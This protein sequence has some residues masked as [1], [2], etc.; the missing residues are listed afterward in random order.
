MADP[1]LFNF[2]GSPK[3][4]REDEGGTSPSIRPW[5]GTLASKADALAVYSEAVQ[6]PAAECANIESIYCA[7]Q[8]KD[9][10][11]PEAKILREDFCSSA[12]VAHHWL[13]LGPEYSS[14]GVDIDLAALQHNQ[15]LFGAR[16]VRI[17]QSS[18]YAQAKDAFGV[19]LDPCD[20][21]SGTER[22]NPVQGA[23]WAPG[24]A[25]DR[26]DR[27]LAKKLARSQ[28]QAVQPQQRDLLTQNVSQT[29]PSSADAEKPRL[30]LLHADVLS[31]PLSLPST[32]QIPPPDV[33]ASLNYALCYFHDRAGLLGYLRQVVRTLRSHTGRFVCDQFAGP[34][35]NEIYPEQTPLWDKFG[36][37]PGFMRSGDPRPDPGN[38]DV[39][40]WRN[41][42]EHSGS[43]PADESHPESRVGSSSSS[44]HWP[45]GNLLLVRKG[46][47]TPKIA[48]GTLGEEQDFEYWREDGPVDYMTNRFRMSLSFRFQDG[49]WLR[50][51][52][53]YDFRV[54]SLCEVIEAMQEAGFAKVTAEVLPRDAADAHNKEVSD[55]ESDSGPEEQPPDQVHRRRSDDGLQDMAS[56]IRRT[57]REERNRSNYEIVREGEMVFAK[58][59]FATY[60]IGHAP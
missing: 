31:L 39:R 6:D 13:S 56:L 34:Q 24:A 4:E 21:T 12:L 44:R 28:K 11:V 30:T 17:L 16:D 3:I 46:K 27:K 60:V 59:S 50:D 15:R 2:G 1:R 26:F 55:S 14:Q 8:D 23:S 22:R 52:F 33:V 38:A 47:W 43:N 49:S 19:Q 18:E 57:E 10:E 41:D 25:T 37:E 45:R 48:H 29:P 36:R 32:L 5:S 54:W 58:R 40:V 35:G 53:A 9:S 20:A 51:V 42:D 7:S